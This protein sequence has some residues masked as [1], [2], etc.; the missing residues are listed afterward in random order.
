MRKLSSESLVGQIKGTDI[1]V[2][3]L[4]WYSLINM[5]LGRGKARVT[6]TCISMVTTSIPALPQLTDTSGSGKDRI[7]LQHSRQASLHS[8][9]QYTVHECHQEACPSGT[10]SIPSAQHRKLQLVGGKM[11]Q[12]GLH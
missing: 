2:L 4:E 10:W 3:T 1:N 12:L 7:G 9:C 8:I 6:L 11:L 5:F